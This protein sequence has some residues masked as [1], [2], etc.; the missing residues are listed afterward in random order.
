MIS[1]IIP[2]YNVEQYIAKCIESILNQT[3]S[4][5]E[6]ILINDGST[7]RSGE[8]CDKYAI[9]N[10]KI[11][12]IHQTNRGV[13]K[14]RN[15]A[16]NIANGE[17]LCFVDSDDWVDPN[18]LED[19][20]T[21]VYKADF[22]F[23]GALYD[24]NNKVYSY[25]NYKE[26]YC[27]NIQQIKDVFFNQKLFSNGY[28]WGKLFKTQIIKNNNLQFNEQL[29]IHEDHIFVFQYF[30][31]INSLYITNSSGYHYLVFDNSGRKLSGRLIK[32]DALILSSKNFA[33][34]VNMLK[35]KWDLT[36]EQNN[37]LNQQFIFSKRLEA[38]RSLIL[39]NKPQHFTTEQKFWLENPYSGIN[40]KEKIIL[41]IL[42]SK[43]KIKYFILYILIHIL[44]LNRRINLTR[45]IYN[46]L[47]NRSTK[48]D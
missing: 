20:K 16:I 46:D 47:N 28:P 10:K 4:D 26:S 15:T 36:K 31:Y 6:L 1:I 40:R 35:Q 2:V 45:I 8:I 25:K 21:N 13:S 30:S 33:L 41:R 48:L 32:Y 12:V 42:R 9:N 22:Y 24:I 3:N 17:Y 18:F 19:F 43:S 23:S 44:E 7:D 37:F 39:Q 11:K 14:S 5:W 29:S 27:K 34:S 38:I